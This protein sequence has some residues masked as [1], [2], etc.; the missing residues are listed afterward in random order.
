M[1]GPSSHPVRPNG[2]D[3]HDDLPIVPD[4]LVGAGV[5][6]PQPRALPYATVL[7]P[8]HP[9]FQG[10]I[11]AWRLISVDLL[12]S[13]VIAAGVVVLDCALAVTAGYGLFLARV[14]RTAT[15]VR[16]LVLVGIV[17]PTILLSS[18]STSCWSPFTYSIPIRAS[19]SPI[20]YMPPHWVCSSFIRTCVDPT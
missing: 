13:L 20:P 4:L 12:H 15:L 5:P 19:S 6:E 1:G 9:T 17:F 10:Y 7:L 16:L 8:P 18:P 3:N 2:A 14:R 11:G